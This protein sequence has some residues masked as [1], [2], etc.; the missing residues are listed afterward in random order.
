MG[1]K[2][3]LA[4][5]QEIMNQA[6]EQNRDLSPDEKRE[7][8]DLQ[9]Q[10]EELE[11]QN[12]P[13]TEQ[14]GGQNPEG[15]ETEAQRALAEERTRCKEIRQLCRSFGMDGDVDG[16]ID[17]GNTVEEVRGMVLE[18]LARDK[19]PIGARVTE[20]E[21]DKFRAAAV[22]G[23]ALRAGVAVSKP[24]DGANDFRGMSL[25]NLAIECLSRE[26]EDTRD[27]L[28]M[29]GDQLYDNL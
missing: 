27:M 20:D 4:R 14:T 23:L 18:K 13:G 15:G 2:E 10:L 29:S 6:K 16:Y 9:T 25:K 22:D 24:A 28:R 8:D 26:G 7:W 12:P 11:R 5:Q 1:K 21:G 17:S 19:S 3:I